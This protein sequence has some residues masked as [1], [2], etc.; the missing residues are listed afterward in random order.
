MPTTPSST[1]VMRDQDAVPAEAPLAS[2]LAMIGQSHASAVTIDRL[3]P[4]RPT[5]RWALGAML[6]DRALRGDVIRLAWP[7]V[8]EQLL[9]TSVGLVDV[10][11]IGR[12]G[13]ASLAGSGLGLQIIMVAISALSAFGIG[14]TI[15]VAQATGRRD[16]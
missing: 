12:L 15:L 4:G 1:T 16:P 5:N 2:K 7:V 9:A 13:S 3:T 6:G 10:A 14:T 11:V 8:V